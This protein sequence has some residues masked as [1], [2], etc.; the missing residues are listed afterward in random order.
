[1]AS[2]LPGRARTDVDFAIGG[3]GTAADEPLAATAVGVDCSDAANA[4]IR[5]VPWSP[6]DLTVSVGGDTG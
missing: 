5:A 2:F 3:G 1:M 6:P 4:A